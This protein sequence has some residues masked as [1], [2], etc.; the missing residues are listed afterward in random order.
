VRVAAIVPVFERPTV[1]VEALDSVL[2]QRTPPARLVVVDDGSKDATAA[3]LEDWLGRRRPPFPAEIIRQARSGVS[4]ARNRGFAAAGDVEIVAFLDS[5]DLWP[6]DYLH[7]MTRALAEAPEVIAASCDK[8][9]LDVPSGRA[10]TV[11]RRW[12][13]GSVTTEIVR[14]GPPGISNTVIRASALREAGGFDEALETAEDLDLM[15]RL[16]LLGAWRW[17]REV[18]VAY[19]HRLGDVRG[20]ARALGHQH[21]DRRRTRAL[22]LEGF[23]ER[24]GAR[25]PAAR[26]S[27]REAVGRHWAKAGRQL[28]REGRADEAKECFR[29]AIVYRPLD[30]RSR[31]ALLR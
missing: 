22:V 13:E 11:D 31:W 1:V 17:V 26:A 30:V 19:R 14:R 25:L 7:A 28:A 9:S 20:E 3:A 29:R 10:R 18:Q 6:P 27:L 23:L 21:A 2:A 16:S 8:R 12:A 5:D 24:A 15:L 4:A